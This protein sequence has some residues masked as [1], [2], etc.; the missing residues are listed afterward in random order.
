M[1]ALVNELRHLLTDPN[2]DGASVPTG[3]AVHL[4]PAGLPGLLSPHGDSRSFSDPDSDH[5]ATLGPASTTSVT[6]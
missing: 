5:L 1:E 2:L 6:I 4:D 3:S